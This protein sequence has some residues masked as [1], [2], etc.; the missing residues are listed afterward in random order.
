M[1]QLFIETLCQTSLISHSLPVS[2]SF[3]SFYSSFCTLSCPSFKIQKYKIVYSLQ[4]SGEVW[5]N[6]KTGGYGIFTFPSTRIN[7]FLVLKIY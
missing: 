3:L 6:L 1:M 4:T 2:W 7:I 5:E